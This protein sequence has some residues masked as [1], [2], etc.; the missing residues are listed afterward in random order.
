M[1]N[2][3]VETIIIRKPSNLDEVQAYTNNNKSKTEKVLVTEVIKLS[4]SDYE[5]LVNNFSGD[6]DYLKGKGGFNDTC[7]K[8]VLVYC[9]NKPYLVI[10][11]E[12]YSYARYVGLVNPDFKV[13]KT[14]N[15][16]WGCWNG[17]RNAFNEE[18]NLML[19]Y[20]NEISFAIHC[21]SDYPAEEVRDFLD[22][23]F[24][25]HL[26]DEFIDTISKKESFITAFFEKYSKSDISKIHTYYC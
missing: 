19:Q 21:L 4:E 14:K 7:R 8:V 2:A 24:G 11:P 10:D 12:G 26:V 25:R 3:I 6:F 16:S 15:E 22:S 17:L 13:L 5:K 23:R 1:K 20:W 9:S 18:E